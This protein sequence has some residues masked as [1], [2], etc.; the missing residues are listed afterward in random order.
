MTRPPLIEI[1]H[2]CLPMIDR[3][4]QVGLRVDILRATKFSTWCMEEKAAR[5]RDLAQL[6]GYDVNPNSGDQVAALLFGYLSLPTDGIR[7]TASGYRLRAD[8]KALEGLRDAHPAV[9]PILEYRELSKLQSTYAEAM[10]RL[11]D[12]DGRLHANFRV[13]R[14]PTGRL[15]AHDPNLLAMPTRTEWGREIRKCIVPSPGHE[16]F[17]ID[18]DQ[19]EM[20]WTASEAGD[21]AMI[22]AFHSGA[23]IHRLT[24][25]ECFHVPADQVTADQR[26]SGKIIGFG[27]LNDMTGAGLLD[28]FRLNHIR[29]YSLERCNQFVHD[30]H[31]ARPQVADWKE[32][33][34]AHARRY[35]WVADAWGRRRY[36]PELKSSLPRLVADGERAAVN[37]P[38]QGG[39]QGVI[40][41][42]MAIIWKEYLP[43]IQAVAYCEPLLQVHDELLFEI[44]AGAGPW[45]GPMLQDAMAAAA[46]C[47]VPIK[48]KW[49]VGPT[50]GDLEK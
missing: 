44:E 43:E 1:D 37:H 38:I 6:V 27:I 4:G 11:T 45:I 48:S 3:M 39:A 31:A 14:V 29:D 8:D 26:K 22:A 20:R 35:G 16:L 25:A 42:A 13:T 9:P 17:T 46:E 41:S 2:A 28:Q 32:E 24:A 49:A 33:N 47:R 12:S 50:W 30:W 5:R 34:R 10:I 40:K 7:R 21:A 15:A 23:D 19:I 36:F 18:L